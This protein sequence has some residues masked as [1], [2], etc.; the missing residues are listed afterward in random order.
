M[1]STSAPEGRAPDRAS[2]I[3]TLLQENI[4]SGHYGPGDRLPSEADLCAHFKVSRPTLREALGRLTARG[5]IA[6]RRGAGGGAFVT[7]PSAAVAGE[8]IATLIALSTRAEDNA[9]RPLLTEA[10]IQLQLGC[11]ELAV[12]R[13]ADIADLRAEIDLQSDFSIPDSDFVASMR[14]MNLALAVA[15][16]NPAMA[17]VAQGLIEAEFAVTPQTGYA[18]RIRARFLSYHVR[19]ANGIAGGRADDTRAALME[20]WSFESDRA[21]AGEGEAQPVE[22]PPR[23]RDLRLPPVQRLNPLSE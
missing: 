9:H 6:A 23:M 19:I 14:R 3:A 10:R 2:A 17:M 5:L 16:G 7:Q 15:S 18:T 12:L 11:A 8:Q 22:R 4:L 1:S 13:K 20:L 21:G